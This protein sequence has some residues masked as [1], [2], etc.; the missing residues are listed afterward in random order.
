VGSLG[1]AMFDKLPESEVSVQDVT[2][3]NSVVY[4]YFPFGHMK[5]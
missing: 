1:D 4:G 3:L 2:S 5:E